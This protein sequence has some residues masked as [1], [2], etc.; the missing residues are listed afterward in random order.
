LIPVAEI[1]GV[2]LS[3]GKSSRMGKDKSF[4]ELDGKFSITKIYEVLKSVIGMVIVSS[5]EVE[6]YKFLDIPIV[7]DKFQDFGPLSGIL[8]AMCHSVNPHILIVP[9]DMPMITKEILI[10]LI[11]ESKINKINIVKNNER[12]LPLLGI[13]P[14]EVKDSLDEFLRMGNKKVFD[15]LYQQKESINFINFNHHS[16]YLNNM[17]TPVE[18]EWILNNLK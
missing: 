10:K 12:I 13:Y 14:T 17:N 6:K 3:G 16:I 15:F 1:T 9:C 5:D 2:I 7:K 18:Y 4:L 8:A 11:N